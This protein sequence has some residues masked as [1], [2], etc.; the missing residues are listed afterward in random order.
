MYSVVGTK[1]D[2]LVG[3]PIE[4]VAELVAQMD[5]STLKVWIEEF[6]VDFDPIMTDNYERMIKRVK[7]YMGGYFGIVSLMLLNNYTAAKS[8][9]EKAESGKLEPIDDRVRFLF[10]NTNDIRQNHGTINQDMI[11][12]YKDIYSA[13][14]DQIKELDLHNGYFRRNTKPLSLEWE[15]LEMYDNR[16]RHNVQV[17]QAMYEALWILLKFRI[18]VVALFPKI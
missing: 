9:M 18:Y 17:S 3:T 5:E 10:V 4:K 11:D 8:V 2:V 1:N 6:E 12:E 7:N 13:V 14:T 16:I 15:D